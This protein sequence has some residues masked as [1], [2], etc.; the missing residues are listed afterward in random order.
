MCNSRLNSFDTLMNCFIKLLSN[1][2]DISKHTS[3]LINN[4]RQN[5]LHNFTV[6][7]CM[8]C[9]LN[10]KLDMLLN[11]KM[12]HQDI[13]LHN[14]CLCNIFAKANKMCNIGIDTKLLLDCHTQYSLKSLCMCCIL[15]DKINMIAANYS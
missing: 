7:H 10:Y 14:Q 1:L 15:F 8:F 6:A 4:T 13:N 9:K 2:K 12:T 5:I 11:S 3:C